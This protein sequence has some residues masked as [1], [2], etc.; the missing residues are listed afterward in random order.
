MSFGYV[1]TPSARTP[2][3]VLGTSTES[4]S[5]A[6]CG[7][8]LHNYLRLGS[9]N[10]ASEVQKLQNF[11]NANLGTKLASGV[12]DTDTDAAVK[13]FQL[14]YWDEVLKPWVPTGL[15]NDHTPTGYV[16]K[17]T[18]RKINNLACPALN[19]PTPSLQ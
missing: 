15:K 16:Y 10:D 2:G 12:F 17:T 14:K 1:N 3:V 13:T 19:L 9:H 4:T 8:L 6:S 18:L 5:T 7:P 11:L